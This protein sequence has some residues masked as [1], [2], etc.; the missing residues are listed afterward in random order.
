MACLGGWRLQE[1]PNDLVRLARGENLV[2]G[3][4]LH[5]SEHLSCRACAVWLNDPGLQAAP[6]VP[7][8]A[9]LYLP[10]VVSSGICLTVRPSTHARYCVADPNDRPRPPAGPSDQS[11]SSP[12]FHVLLCDWAQI[13]VAN[14]E[15]R[16]TLRRSEHGVL[17]FRVADPNDRP[18]L[19]VG[20]SDQNPSSPCLQLIPCDWAQIDVPN[21]ENH[22]IL[23]RFPH[24]GR[25]LH[26]GPSGPPRLRA[27][28][29]DQNPSDPCFLVLRSGLVVDFANLE[30]CP[31]LHRSQHVRLDGGPH[32]RDEEK[33][34]G[35][36]TPRICVSPAPLS[37]QR[38]EGPAFHLR[39]VAVLVDLSHWK[40]DFSQ[41]SVWRYV[42]RPEGF[43][44]LIVALVS[45]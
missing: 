21:W 33:R 39:E 17:H 44:R 45:S 4:T 22:P 36:L 3:Q 25:H 23:P 2:I 38:Q 32:D 35:A 26:V 12:C 19:P 7:D 29:S 42:C 37:R 30:I 27:G 41:V 9:T 1:A 13:D 24:T 34:E 5:R 15:S 11:P 16:P 18:R 43:A 10:L 40:L 31:I 28:P 6:S 14:W 20:P 8:F